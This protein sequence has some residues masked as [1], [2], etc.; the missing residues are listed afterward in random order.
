MASEEVL[1]DAVDTLHQSEFRP[2]DAEIVESI[3][4]NPF[5]PQAKSVADKLKAKAG[6]GGKPVKLNEEQ[7]RAL[8]Y[9]TGGEGRIKVLNG[10]AGTG[11]TTLLSAMEQAYRRQGYEVIGCSV[12][13]VAA[14]RAANRRGNRKRHRRHAVETVDA[15]P[16]THVQASR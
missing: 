11:K 7:V 1:I 12:A 13:G 14:T 6:R 2:L 15:R 9:L 8:R 4:A 5:Y 3:I 10:L 16:G